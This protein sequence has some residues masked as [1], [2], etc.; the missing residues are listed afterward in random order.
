MRR[1]VYLLLA[2]LL[3]VSLTA[4]GNDKSPGDM[5]RPAL[6]PSPS[7]YVTDRIE[8]TEEPNSSASMGGGTANVGATPQ[9][10]ENP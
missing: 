5:A 4:C 7:P 2:V 6:S 9:T 3:L 1:F 10:S 8:G